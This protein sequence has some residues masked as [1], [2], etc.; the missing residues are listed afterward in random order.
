MHDFAE[1][2]RKKVLRREVI[3]QTKYRMKKKQAYFGKEC[4]KEHF[5]RG[6]ESA[7]GHEV[8]KDKL[9]LLRVKLSRGCKIKSLYVYCFLNSRT[10]HYIMKISLPVPSKAKAKASVTIAIFLDWFLNHFVPIVEHFCLAKKNPFQD[11]PC[12]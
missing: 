1:M 2:L 9:R 10:L 6:K 11:S 7:P 3:C 4:L 12:V 8:S 5:E